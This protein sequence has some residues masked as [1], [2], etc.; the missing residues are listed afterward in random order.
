MRR[1]DRI[2]IYKNN[3]LK[4]QKVVKT[5]IEELEK[6]QYDIVNDS[7]DLAISIG[8]DGTFLR[9]VHESFFDDSIYYIGINTGSLGFLQELNLDDCPDFVTKLNQDQFKEGSISIQET[10]IMTKTGEYYFKSLNEIVI[11]DSRLKTFEGNIQIDE[12]LLESFAGDGILIA[13]PT[14]STAYNVSLG[15]SIIHQ[16]MGCL[17]MTPIAP[18]KNK[19]YRCLANSLIVPK[20][21]SILVY[22]K[23][24]SI[25]IT[26]DGK[27]HQI[28]DVISIKTFMGNQTIKCLKTNSSSFIRA[29]N[30]KLL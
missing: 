22:P 13:T 20:K 25:L 14:G 6:N 3:S 19:S 21:A 11:R 7:C 10:K 27:T 2:K 9:M 17:I 8:G 28:N 16:S 29:I 5:I 4:T 12:E 23:N 18:L 1:I 24:T 26:V 30:Q 15:G